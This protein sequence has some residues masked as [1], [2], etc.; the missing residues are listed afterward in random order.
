MASIWAKVLYERASQD[1]GCPLLLR[2]PI[3]TRDE[4]RY[5]LPAAEINDRYRVELRRGLQK[6]F[7]PQKVTQTALKRLDEKLAASTK[8]MRSAQSTAR[9]TSPSGG[10]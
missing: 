4:L 10:D 8:C 7:D 6:I 2:R 5:C 9:R 1:N 3:L